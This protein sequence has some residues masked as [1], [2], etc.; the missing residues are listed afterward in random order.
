LLLASR[1]KKKGIAVKRFLFLLFVLFL[2]LSAGVAW[3][4]WTQEGARGSSGSSAGACQTASSLGFHLNG[5]DETVL[6]NSTLLSFYNAGG[7]CLAID[8]GKT[9]RANG[10]IVLPNAGTVTYGMP[11][12][13]ITSLT[14]SG[15]T[16]TA[17]IAT[18][19]SGAVSNFT[20]A[21]VGV[22]VLIAGASSSGYNGPVTITGVNGNTFTYTVSSGLST[23]ATG[24]ITFTGLGYPWL[25]P[26][27]RLTSFC[28]GPGN[29]SDAIDCTNAQ[30]YGVSGSSC[31]G[32][33]ISAMQPSAVLDLRY[34][35]SG[36]TAYQGGPKL[37]TLGSGR[38]EIDHLTITTGG[39]DCATLFMSTLT[40]VNL[41]DNT[42]IGYR[43]SGQSWGC[44]DG[45]QLGGSNN[46]TAPLT[47][48]VLD[49]YTGYG[50]EIHDNFFSRSRQLIAT[51]NSPN[52]LHIHHNS[53]DQ[54]C[55]NNTGFQAP[56]NMSNVTGSDISFNLVELY[57]YNNGFYLSG[58]VGNTFIGNEFWD[59]STAYHY[60]SDPS[61]PSN[62]IVDLSYPSTLAGCPAIYSAANANTLVTQGQVLAPKI[63]FSDGSWM[64][65]GYNNTGSPG[66]SVYIDTFGGNDA[67]AACSSTAPCRTAAKAYAR[68]PS[69]T[70][71]YVRVAGGGS[72]IALP[73]PSTGWYSVQAIYLMTE[74]GG[75]TL[76]DIANGFN[77]P[78]NAAHQP[79]W[80]TGGLAFS[81]SSGQYIDTNPWTNVAGATGS[82]TQPVTQI[83]VDNAASHPS[84][85]GFL[86]DWDG[87]NSGV[88]RMYTTINSSGYLDIYAGGTDT[89]TSLSNTIG[90]AEM[91]ASVFNGANSAAYRNA[92]AAS[93]NPLNPGSSSA[94]GSFNLG[95]NS[96]ANAFYNGTLSLFMVV[97]GAL[98]ASDVESTIYPW[99]K[100]QMSTYHSITLP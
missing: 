62:Y 7:G 98:T 33:A 85:W 5:T 93:Q 17:T 44:N 29:F 58:A 67:S 73:A 38:L 65:T 74:K 75:T 100:T 81:A 96:Y 30:L 35:G 88:G 43:A 23:P 21:L 63:A 40:S 3:G 72:Y 80:G 15:T 53:N 82:M 24:T 84:N 20:S 78:F 41:H 31:M 2:A 79:T 10:Q 64:T 46:T 13:L 37:L 28:G 27:Y 48:T 87:N 11:P 56:Y 47:N 14:S 97:N 12:Y 55:G 71:A 60:C 26:P 86:F 57:G 22:P 25:Q 18:S 59:S 52:A 90:T 45:I 1:Y 76:H 32:A 68:A 36:I 99:V 94:G 89:S 61:S 54:S 95:A 66:S 92:A 77:I 34:S 91:V 70:T 16:A 19:G 83:F 50:S 69:A 8:C 49:R 4:N 39:T 9:L 42:W 6:L 51:S